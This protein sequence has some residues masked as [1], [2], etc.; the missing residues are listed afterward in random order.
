MNFRRTTGFA[1]LGCILMASCYP[2]DE[3][4]GR[5]PQRRQPA[6]LSTVPQQQ[7][8]QEQRVAMKAKEDLAREEAAKI[9][10]QAPAV[11]PPETPT[12][13][14]TPAPTP[15]PVVEKKPE[16]K[17]ATKV[18]GKA[19]FVFSPYNNKMIDVRGMSSGTL[20]QDPTYTGDGKGYFRVP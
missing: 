10:D 16:Y 5:K 4:R 1:A 11:T 15:P 14:T 3:N 13:P 18:P 7:A 6:P 2:Y 17:F 8:L 12:V 9:A 20:V 19:G